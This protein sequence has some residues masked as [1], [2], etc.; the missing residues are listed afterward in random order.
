MLKFMLI[1]ASLFAL[2]ACDNP[3]N[4]TVVSSSNAVLAVNAFG[5]VEA[6]A[7]Q[8]LGLPLC[9]GATVCRTKALST[10]IA[11]AVRTGIAARNSIMA[12]LNSNVAAPITTIDAL[13]ASVSALQAL[14]A[15]GATQ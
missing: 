5:V 14:N 2:A 9:P 3:L 10:S 6:T 4:P 11:S 13:N 15:Q 7:T 8:Y 1:G 12:D